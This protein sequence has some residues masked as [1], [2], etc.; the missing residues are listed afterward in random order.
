MTQ[1]TLLLAKQLSA[2]RDNRNLPELA[3]FLRT[4]YPDAEQTRQLAIY[5]QSLAR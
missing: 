4:H 3:A 1:L 5:Q 2:Q